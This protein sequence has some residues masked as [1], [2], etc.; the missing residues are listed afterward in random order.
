MKFSVTFVTLCYNISGTIVEKY[1]VVKVD[2]DK[3]EEQLQF[4]YIE[5]VVGFGWTNSSF[6]EA[7]AYLKD[8]Q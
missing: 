2:S 1:D 4:G 8:H 6:L 3:L 5:N 7:E